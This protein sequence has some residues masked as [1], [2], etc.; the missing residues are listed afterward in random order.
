MSASLTW[1][2]HSIGRAGRFGDRKTK[3]TRHI[4]YIMYSVLASVLGLLVQDDC[5]TA[6]EAMSAGAYLEST[7]STRSTGTL[8]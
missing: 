4:T 8:L 7:Y 5:S 1:L 6:L 2:C 3:R